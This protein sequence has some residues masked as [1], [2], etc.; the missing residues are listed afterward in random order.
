MR[1][2]FSDAPVADFYGK[3]FYSVSNSDGKLCAYSENVFEVPEHV[4]F[5]PGGKTLIFEKAVLVRG[6]I[7]GGEIRG[8]VI[9]GGVIW[10]G[11]IWGSVIWG[12]EICGARV[13]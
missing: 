4:T 11:V 9:R 7:R 6:E 13:S 8:G 5:F 10:G 12:G 2:T 1:Y 3:K